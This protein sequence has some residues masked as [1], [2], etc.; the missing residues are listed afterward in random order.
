MWLL[1]ACV[2]LALVM[3]CRAILG[4]RDF[5]DAVDASDG[6][7]SVGDGSIGD[8]SDLLDAAAADAAPCTPAPA[9]P[10]YLSNA[11]QVVAGLGFSCALLEDG[12][13]TC[14]GSNNQGQLGNVFTGAL[15]PTPTAI[16]DGGV[17]PRFVQIAAGDSF[18]CAIDAVGTIWCWGAGESGQL[19]HGFSD[20][21]G[22]QPIAASGASFSEVAAGGDHACAR[23]HL[24][25]DNVVCWGAGQSLELGA[26]QDGGPKL[27]SVT[28]P[29]LPIGIALGDQHGCMIADG[30][31]VTCWG[32]DNVGQLATASS[33]FDSSTGISAFPGTSDGTAIRAG[34]NDTCVL[35][36]TGAYCAGANS[37]NQL[38]GTSRQ[39]VTA[40][41]LLNTI[42]GDV[43]DIALGGTHACLW[44]ADGQLFCE[45]A[46]A[47]GELGNGSQ[48]N[49]AQAIATPVKFLDGGGFGPV[50][51]AAVA[52]QTFSIE[53][54]QLDGGL[55]HSCAIVDRG[56][57]ISGTV[58]CWGSNQYGELGIGDA[59]TVTITNPVPVLAP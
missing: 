11:T 59:S 1:T 6:D 5:D 28:T 54:A 58:Y 53:R 16:G 40:P 35:T 20:D 3:G 31:A 51:R 34:G 57:G 33:T 15:H 46:N 18:V 23:P 43:K 37:T 7:G 30:G 50:L 19:G 49:D 14:W 25:E 42:P 29:T 24:G 52:S 8:G 38:G 55:P 27:V 9:D 47:S 39:S 17:L 2:P 10:R 4:V 44:S 21:W 41:K 13:V 12:S 36:P 56:C 48:A 32:A 26:V 22:P 45:G